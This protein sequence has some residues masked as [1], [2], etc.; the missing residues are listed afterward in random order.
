LAADR[1]SRDHHERLADDLREKMRREEAAKYF[2]LPTGRD[3]KI[4]VLRE[5]ETPPRTSAVVL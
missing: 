3:V 5:F 1:G 4:P 2:E